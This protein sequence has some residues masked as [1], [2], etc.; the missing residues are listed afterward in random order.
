MRK[1]FFIFSLIALAGAG[2]GQLAQ[3]SNNAPAPKIEVSAIS[4]TEN[5]AAL[6]SEIPQ[7]EVSR[8]LKKINIPPNGFYYH[9]VYPGGVGTEEDQI[10]EG[11]LTAYEKSAGKKAAWVYFTHNWF[12]G[13]GFPEATSKWIRARG[14]IPY[15]RLMPRSSEEQNVAEPLYTLDNINNGKFDAE[16]RAWMMAAKN[17]GTP[18]LVEFGPEVNGEWFQWNGVWNGKDK[19]PAKFREAY[20]RI[21][22]F[23]RE[24]GAENITW[25]FHVNNNDISE[26]A[27]NKL[28]NYYPGKE[29]VDWVGVSIY[30][31]TSPID[32]EAASFRDLMDAIYPRLAKLDG[33]KPIIINEFGAGARHPKVNQ[34][35][36]AD[37]A[38]KN[39]LS[40]RWPRVIGF[41]WWNEAWQNDDDPAHDSNMRLQ[42]NPALA[43]VFK[44]R[45][46]AASN[47]LTNDYAR[48]SVPAPAKEKTLRA[49]NTKSQTAPLSNNAGA[50]SKSPSAASERAFYVSPQ[51]NNANPGTIVKPWKTIQFAAERLTAG[52]TVYIR[53]GTYK[54]RVVPQNSGA[55]D[56]YITYSAYPGE[57]AVI[58][59]AGVELPTG[60][61]YGLIGIG[62]KSFIKI[63]GLKI[64]NAAT[65]GGSA[66]ILVNG[67]SHHITISKNYISNAQSSGIGV[68]NAKNIIIDG[69]EI[70]KVTIS[71]QQEAISVARVDGF[72]VKNNKVHDIDIPADKE[73]ICIKDGSANGKV[74]KNLIYNTPA[75]GIYVDAWDKHTYNI[76]VFQN[77]VYGAT[78]SDGFQA[79][80]EMG[81][82][83]ENIKFYNNIGYGN[84][85]RGL[86]VTDNGDEGGPHPMKNITVANNTFYNNGGEWGGC[87]AVDDSEAKEVVIRNN[88]C[89]RNRSFEIS[90]VPA[91][92]KNTTVANNLIYEYKSDAEDNEVRGTYSV[93]ADPMFVDAANADFHLRTGSPA[94]DKGYR[95]SAPAT[96]FDGRARPQ[97]GGYDIGA[98]E[99]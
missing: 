56:K 83:L 13:L 65:D 4:K 81:G 78:N 79:A 49:P 29:W 5:P 77:V 15:I 48:P 47:V 86:T 59:G 51:G 11:D 16:L 10:T 53:K 2:C 57:E 30:S 80:S 44:K 3:D 67:N 18:I 62:G 8:K 45:I 21:V 35:S 50:P 33:E 36:W 92:V 6:A 41:S 32:D 71:G 28:E 75:A 22:R 60:D 7:G 38:L 76:E 19:G 24:E 12:K 82:L 93:E 14:S 55:A 97:G 63:N 85:F 54:E 70:Q 31:A 61:L 95:I 17:F 68:W 23:A 52:D 58:D 42:D 87:I 25:G 94:I 88:I 90:V 9:G 72:E 64:I 1:I 20:R 89:S 40:G 99:K 43:K 98:F 34:A 39:V 37:D 69:N 66:G 91:A 96:D 74:F 46:G 73:G 84:K 27:W 26:N